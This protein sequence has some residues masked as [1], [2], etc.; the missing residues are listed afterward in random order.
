MPCFVTSFETEISLT[1]KNL[2]LWRI[3]FEI[4]FQALGHADF[5]PNGGVA[6]QP[7][8]VQEEL[9]KNNFVGI[10]GEYWAFSHL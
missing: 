5:Y 1:I 9:N 2:Y 4:L 8:C 6:L 3:D 7:G 10:V